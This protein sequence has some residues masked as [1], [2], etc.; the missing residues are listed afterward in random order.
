ML[1]SKFLK[2]AALSAIPVAMAMGSLSA[3]AQA[4]PSKAIN[5]VVPF[6]AG[7]AADFSARFMTKEM[8]ITLKQPMLVDNV[9]GVAGAL[10]VMKGLNAAPDGHTTHAQRH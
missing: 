4:F 6:P 9:T 8:T 2:V 3:F 10:G 1:T 5:V 7:G